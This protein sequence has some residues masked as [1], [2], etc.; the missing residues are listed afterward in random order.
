M[1]FLDVRLRGIDASLSYE[2]HP[3]VKSDAPHL[4]LLHGHSSS[5]EE[6][7]DLLPA[8]RARAHVYVFDQPGCGNSSDVDVAE[9]R[10]RYRGWPALWFLRSVCAEFVRK[11]V[12]PK[13]PGPRSLRVAGG[14][15][16]GNLALV[17]TERG[18]PWLRDA[19]VWSPASAWR[20]DFF[21]AAGSGAALRRAKED[22]AG[23]RRRFLEDRFCRNVVDVLGIPGLTRPQPWYWYYDGWGGGPRDYRPDFGK[24]GSRGQDPGGEG[25]WDAKKY[26]AMSRRKAEAIAGSFRQCREAYSARRAAWHW[27]VAG[28]QLGFSHRDRLRGPGGKA[29]R[30]ARLTRSVTFLAGE[31][32]DAAPADL[33]RYT[34]ELWAEAS[35]WA[36]APV[37]LRFSSVPGSG[38]SIHNEKPAWLAA[39]LLDASPE[40][41]PDA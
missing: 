17:L 35:R 32:D 4:L 15:L 34:K 2:V 9:V 33:H 10:R 39:L 29:P 12:L 8:L 36:K 6:F 25:V 24:R 14:S 13:L 23:A 28:E 3:A 1:P 20:G 22:W 37:E 5:V 26:P 38:H 21:Q 27:Q 16:G 41:A 7:S 11:L 18:Y 40:R 30:I 31:H 19:V